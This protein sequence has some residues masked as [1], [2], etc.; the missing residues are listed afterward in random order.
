ML[1]HHDLLTAPGAAPTK[2][3]VFLHGILGS[4]A[5]LRSHARRFI[6]AHPEFLAALIDLRAHGDSLG[7]DGPDTIANA[8]QDVAQTA[9]TWSVPVDAVVGH[10]F[11]GKVAL[12]FAQAQPAV[13]AVMT[14]D[15]APGPR[16]DARGSETTM[17]VLLML[18]AFRLTWENREAFVAQVEAK[19]LSRALGQWLAMN[20][21][22]GPTGWVFRLDLARIH[23]LIDDY[24]EVD[25]WPVVEAAAHTRKGP[26]FHLVIGSKSNVYAHEDR[27]RAQSLETESEGFVTVDLLDAGHWVHVDDPQGLSAV[28]SRRLGSDRT[29]HRVD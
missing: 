17:Q 6:Q 10:S 5:N 9:R 19:G 29:E 21:E 20:L 25:L 15:S 22:P 13:R 23:A 24:F 4:G 27:V 2:A 28:L 18:E 3:V 12:A 14:L 11:G 16:P 7:L 8:A 1:L 26:R